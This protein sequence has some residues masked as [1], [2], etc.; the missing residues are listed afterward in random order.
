MGSV[1]SGDEANRSAGR[2]SSSGQTGQGAQQTGRTVNTGGHRVV[3]TPGQTGQPSRPVATADPAMEASRQAARRMAPSINR[4]APRQVNRPASSAAQPQAADRQLSAREQVNAYDPE[5]V[6]A[7]QERLARQRGVSHQGYQASQTAR[8]QEERAAVRARQQQAVQQKAQASAVSGGPRAHV[9]ELDLNSVQAA[10]KLYDID[11]DA[12]FSARQ[13]AMSAQGSRSSGSPRAGGASGGSGSSGSSGGSGHGGSGGAG[14]GKPPRG[15]KGGGNGKKD[16]GA[17][18]G[19]PYKGKNGKKKKFAW[20]KTL[21]ITIG[22]IVLILGGAFFFI[23]NAIGPSSGSIS[24]DQLINTP[25]EFQGKELNILVTGIDRSSETGN[26]SDSQVNDG[27]TDMILYLHFNNETGEVKMLQVPRDTMV[28]TDASV[29]GNYRINGVAKTQGTDGNNNMAALCKLFSQQYKLPVDG[30]MTIRLEMLVEMVD[31]FG[32]V[33][34]NVPI[35][36]DFEGSHLKAGYQTLP[37]AACEFLL[38]ARKIYPDGD[39]GRLNM[40]RQFYSALFRK[41]KSIDNIFDVAKLTPAL[42]NYME[43]DLSFSQLSSFAVSMLKTDSSKMMICQMPVFSGPTYKDQALVYPAR[44]QDADLLNQ[45]FRENTG[46]V[47][48]ADLELCDNVIDLSGL[49]AT[50]P[51]LQYMGA[52]MEGDSEAQ[53]EHNLDGSNQ[54]TY[55]EPEATAAPDA[56]SGSESNASSPAA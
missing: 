54:V 7:A 42:L 46:P 8:E 29:S 10:G 44:Q 55:A 47:E 50:D 21:L 24:L 53:K 2:A 6:R 38:R 52:I 13:P 17:G 30:Y 25:K 41:L 18:K 15:G 14:G 23:L 16:G 20:W 11:G 43:T 32:G 19:T 45:Y 26:E 39:M 35:D 1:H 12:E 33:E 3:R 28:T 37:G 4:P 56:E 40:Q 22:V 27:M 48:A 31:Q 51:N 9:R 5:A 49:T 36:M 34:L